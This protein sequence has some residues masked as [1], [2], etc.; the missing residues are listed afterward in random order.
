M[1]R[2][3]LWTAL[4][5]ATTAVQTAVNAHASASTPQTR[6]AMDAAFRG[7]VHRLP[8]VIGNAEASKYEA[9]LI[10]YQARAE[11]LKAKLSL[12]PS[13]D[14]ADRQRR[15]QLT[16]DLASAETAFDAVRVALGAA[17]ERARALDNE[18][19]GGA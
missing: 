10:A 15:Q 12:L 4:A 2:E 6:E 18:R 7:Y 13:L 17:L 5:E 3:T 19:P 16:D 8:L 9:G 1:T 14:D 11:Q